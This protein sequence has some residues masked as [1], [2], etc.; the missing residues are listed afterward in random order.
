M[1][2]K[3]G[4]REIL[5]LIWLGIIGL[6]LIFVSIQALTAKK[7]LK[8]KD[9]YGEYVINRSFFQGKQADWQYDNFHFE[10]KEDDSIYLYVTHKNTPVKTFSGSVRTVKNYR[11]ERLAINMQLPSHHI[12]ECNP[13]IYRDTW[14]FYLVFNSPKFGNLFFKKGTWESLGSPD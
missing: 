8:K 7:V 1:T 13:T 5:G 2:R 6:I 12:M 11:S 4:Y 3:N 9:F 10:I 14:S